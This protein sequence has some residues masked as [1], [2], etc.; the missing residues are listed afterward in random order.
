MK[1][2]WKIGEYCQDGILVAEIKGTNIR[3]STK[4]YNTKE[5]CQAHTYNEDEKRYIR[6]FLYELT[7]SYYAEKVED[8]LKANS[9]KYATAY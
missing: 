8:W 5:E 9:N 2:Q 3:I 1:K 7:S 6:D 4:D